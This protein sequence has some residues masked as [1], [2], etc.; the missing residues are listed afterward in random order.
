M[1]IIPAVDVLDGQVVR[2]VKGD[3]E[4]VTAYHASPAAAI[5]TWA[6]AG[7]DLVH[8]V[9]LE[10][11]RTG[12][13]SMGL[14]EEMAATSIPFQIGGGIRSER[15][16][17]RMLEAGAARVVL[18]SAAVWEP[19]LLKVLVGRFGGHRLVAALDVKSGM[20]T[21]AGWLDVGRPFGEVIA[22]VATTG[23]GWILA[24][25]IARD[26][27]MSGP[28]LTLTRTAVEMAPEA[29]V[30]GSGGVGTIDD[31]VALKAVGAVAAVV[32][33]AL[34]EHAFTLAD[35]ARAVAQR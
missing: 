27:T 12:N 14:V 31:L 15:V 3:F 32:G 13:P 6:A 7:A 17:A 20:A 9:D 33:K 34:Y 35:A 25:G 11:A 19:D 28:D 29:G 23:V 18:G 8:V 22:E 2:L 10:G 4:A 21:G 16:A 24:T 5:E 1:Q 26:G 30:I